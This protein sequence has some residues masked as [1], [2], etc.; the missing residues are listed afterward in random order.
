MAEDPKFYNLEEVEDIARKVL[1]KSV[2]PIEFDAEAADVYDDESL[3]MQM[4][5]RCMTTS[6]LVQT[7]TQQCETI[8]RHTSG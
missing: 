1:P 3:S 2:S 4:P 6:K 5:Y 8:V 7:Q